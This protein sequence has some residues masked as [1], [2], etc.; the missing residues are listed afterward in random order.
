[1]P[2]WW[3]SRC[4]RRSKIRILRDLPEAELIAAARASILDGTDSRTRV[5]RVSGSLT[6]RDYLERVA[7]DVL[8][9]LEEKR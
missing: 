4:V 3:Q 7:P 6:P 9:E 2:R 5:L 1:M 8:A